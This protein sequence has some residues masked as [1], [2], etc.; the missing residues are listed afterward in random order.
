MVKIL[1]TADGARLRAGLR[2]P[3]RARRGAVLCHPHPD[4]GGSMHSTL[5]A[6]LSQALADDG[7]AALRFDF[8]RPGTVHERRSDVEASIAALDGDDA[9]LVGWSYGADLAMAVGSSHNRVAGIVAV[10]PPLMAINPDELE[11]LTERRVLVL[12]PEHDQFCAPDIIRERLPGTE[13]EV[14]AGADHFCSGVE[15]EIAKRVL[16][17][18]GV[19]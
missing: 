10:A 4:Y 5:I 15:D 6:V 9:L 17:F 3:D 19:L 13:I 2:S 11:H 7:I 14:L 18:E 12:V 1:V 8:R 16:L